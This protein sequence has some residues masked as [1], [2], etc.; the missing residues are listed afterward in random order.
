MKKDDGDRPGAARRG[1]RLSKVR[2]T[3]SELAANEWRAEFR[4]ARSQ[5]RC[6]PAK[7]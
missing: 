3:R 1:G 4:A 7:R 5:P 6:H 2:R